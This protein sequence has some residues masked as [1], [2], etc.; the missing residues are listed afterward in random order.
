M[1]VSG[2]NKYSAGVKTYG[3]GRSAPNV[4]KTRSPGG[5]AERDNKLANTVVPDQS[6]NGGRNNKSVDLRSALLRK[7]KAQQANNHASSAA[8]TPARNLF[9]GPGGN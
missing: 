8:Q 6:R 3:G 2:F 5:Y 1:S 4:G 7:L 9:P